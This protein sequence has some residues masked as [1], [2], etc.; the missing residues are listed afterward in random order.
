MEVHKAEKVP[1]QHG[2][3]VPCSSGQMNRGLRRAEMAARWI[4]KHLR[5]AKVMA[6][7]IV[8]RLCEVVNDVLHIFDAD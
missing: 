3:V 1:L 6:S 5:R 2:H 4:V 7:L 8:K